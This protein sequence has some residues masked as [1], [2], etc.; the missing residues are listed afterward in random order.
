M[1]ISLALPL[2]FI[3]ASVL[4][5]SC[6]KGDDGPIGPS[7]PEGPAGPAGPTG[8][9]NVTQFNF[10]PFEH[11]GLE[12]IKTLALSK[13]DFD[14]SL[15]YVYVNSGSTFWYPMPGGTAGGI[16]DYRIYFNADLTSTRIYLNRIA[17]S[18]S[19]TL[20]MR[21]LVIPA[22]TQ[23]TG[24]AASPNMGNYAAMAAYYGL[25]LN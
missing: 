10:A 23:A 19:E 21:V 13:A 11:S 4:L 20:S 25:P 24:P 1:K 18:G 17:G 22:T 3:T 2:L 14:K 8:T 5:L 15:L 9:A 7:G 12:V 16:K 6:K